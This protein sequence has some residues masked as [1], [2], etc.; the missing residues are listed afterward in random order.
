MARRANCTAWVISW[1]VTH[2]TSCSR[3]TSR[4]RAVCARLGPSSSSRGGWEASSS[5][6]SYWPSTRWESTPIS[7]PTCRASSCRDTE[8]SG[9]AS[10]PALWA[11][12]SVSVPSSGP[13]LRR[14]AAI[15]VGRSITSSGGRRRGELELAVGRDPL[16]EVV[17]ER[18]HRRASH[19]PEGRRAGHQLADLLG[20]APIDRVHSTERSPTARALRERQNRRAPDAPP[21]MRRPYSRS[22]PASRTAPARARKPASDEHDAAAFLERAEVRDVLAWTRLLIEP[23]DAAAVVRALARPPIELRQADLARVIQIARRR[24]LDIVS[25]LTLAVELPQV[26][27]DARERIQ[28]FLD[29]R[30]AAAAA[31]DGVRPDLLARMALGGEREARET[32]RGRATS[33]GVE[34]A[35]LRQTMQMMREE[36]LASVARI[37]GRLGEL[38]L[39]TDLDISHGVVRYLELV[40][41]AALLQRPAGESMQEALDDLNARLL[42]A[43]TP[44]Q[45]EILQTSTLDD[46]LLAGEDDVE[47]RGRGDRA[48][49]DRPPRGAFA[50]PVPAAQGARPGAVGLRRGDLSQLSAALQVRARAAYPDGADAAP[51]LRDHR[52][53][54]A[55][56]LP[57]RGREHARADARSA[58]RSLAQGRLRR[59]RA[60]APA[61]REGARRAR[62]LPRAPAGPGVR[63]GVVRALVRLS[64]RAPSGARARR[65]CR[66]P[67]GGTGRASTS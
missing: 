14:L 23:H 50:R 4:L 53:P 2:T 33:G 18:L 54:R 56:A 28:R 20:G 38:R 59:Q 67:G 12:C 66:S 25:A 7:A 36:V 52:P 55:R 6:R 48:L 30:H 45:R 5:D 24:K 29:L 17:R 32:P 58:G 39:D 9:P 11:I 35:Q 43:A 21:R 34:V 62:A 22:V 1:I 49:A 44:L 10:G 65:P 42:A 19:A 8:R 16:G 60:R 63:A 51:A 57:L 15:H 61:A 46:V 31:L 47:R 64:P 13:M 40:K 41:L 26:P 37:G 27:P 3:S